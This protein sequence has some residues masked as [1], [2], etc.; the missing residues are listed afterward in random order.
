MNAAHLRIGELARE[1]GTKVVTIR[2]YERI[3]LMPEPE[4]SGGNYRAYG[5]A[6]LD[7][8]RFIRRC[9]AL[10]F[11]LEQVRELLDLASDARRPCGEVDRMIGAHLAEVEQKIADLS[12]LAGEL[13]R[14]SDSCQGG[15]TISNCRIVEAIAPD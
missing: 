14:I 8:L 3:G 15:G 12:R 13:R 11:P 5:K 4:R 2:Y 9:R 10:G 1:T 6:A 7:R